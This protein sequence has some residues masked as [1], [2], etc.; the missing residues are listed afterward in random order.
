M[1]KS[2]FD[3]GI[4]FLILCSYFLFSCK[5]DFSRQPVVTTGDFDLAMAIAHGTLVDLGTKEITDHGFCW[6][7]LGETNVECFYR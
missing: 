7:S 1:R 3:Y 4:I 2:L 5:K 6:D